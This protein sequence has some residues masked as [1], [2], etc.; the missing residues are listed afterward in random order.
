M[1]SYFEQNKLS[2]VG[3]IMDALVRGD[4]AVV[5]DAGMPGLS[6]PGYELVQA[7]IERGYPVVPVPGPSAVIAALVVSGLSTD[8]FR[9]LG[10][11]PRR[12]AKRQ[13]ALRQVANER[14]TLVV[15][16]TPQRL[17]SSLDDM[18]KVL[19][20]RQIAMCR[21]L[22]KKF[23]DVWRG[24]ISGARSHCARVAPRGE[25]TL[26]IAGAS[27]VDQWDEGLVAAALSDLLGQGVPRSQAV[28]EVAEFCGWSRRRVYRL[29]LSEEKDD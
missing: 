21:E 7:A 10:F 9:Y 4:V 13:E 12:S 23:E 25:Y 27:K 6:D 29:A 26:V 22:T 16:E 1:I 20:D 15:F 14:C 5:S 17:P 18:E 19:G 8:Q 28:R 11:L 2:R 3:Q 24:T